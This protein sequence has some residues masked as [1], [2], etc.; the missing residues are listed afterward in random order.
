MVQRGVVESNIRVGAG[1]KG[2]LDAGRSRTGYVI[3][4]IILFS[5]IAI[6]VIGVIIAMISEGVGFIAEGY[7]FN[8]LD[9]LLILITIAVLAFVL[10]I[11]VGARIRERRSNRVWA[12]KAE[13]ARAEK[14]KANPAFE[15]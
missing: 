7:H 11:T 12:E 4:R 13:A 1:D 2:H 3:S 6:S 9:V 10:H 14:A 8:L 15:D 5:F